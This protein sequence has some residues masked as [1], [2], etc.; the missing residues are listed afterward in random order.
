MNKTMVATLTK[1]LS[2]DET[3]ETRAME[4]KMITTMAHQ[5]KK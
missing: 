5:K 2:F 1:Q 3:A 4:L